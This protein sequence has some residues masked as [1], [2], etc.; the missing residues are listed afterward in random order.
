MALIRRVPLTMAALAL[1]LAGL[2]NLLSSYSTALKSICGVTA[3]AAA[4]LIL[5]RMA[6]DSARVRSELRNPAALAVFPAFF[7]AV[8]LLATY[9]KPYAAMPATVVWMVALALQLLVSA[10]FM[11][12]LVR[13]FDVSQ[14]LPGWFLAFVGFVVG[15][16][17]SPVFD[18]VPLGRVL[19]YAG[20]GGYA[21]ALPVVGY[22]MLKHGDVPEPALPTVAIFAA[23]PSLLLVGYLTVVPARDS[24]VVYL[25]LAMT[26]LSLAY[27]FWRLPRILRLGFCP[28]CAALTFPFV[29]SAIAL[30]QAQA[31]FASTDAGP[32]FPHAILLAIDILAA[33][34]VVYAFARYAVFFLVPVKAV[35][36]EPVAEAATP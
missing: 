28:S 13:S 1:G 7:M 17:T 32:L 2:G 18:A 35:E 30:K 3:A 34:M 26:G 9:V 8:M 10:T 5:A 12:R 15:S 31:L 24:Y 33:A 16:V 14:A 4:V 19:L 27:V 29:I 21:I 36:V 20:F 23:P 25:L 22:R 6:L 11:V